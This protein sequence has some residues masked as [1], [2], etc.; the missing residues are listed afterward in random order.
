M[1][2]SNEKI[3]LLDKEKIDNF[4][5]RRAALS[6]PRI[7]T[8]FKH[9]TA[10]E[11]DIALVRKFLLTQAHV[12]DLGCGTGAIAKSIAAEC[13]YIRAVDKVSQFLDY[14][15]V[16]KNI[17]VLEADIASY[18]DEHK[19]D[20]VLIFGVMNYLTEIESKAVYRNCYDMLKPG[21]VL[22]VKHAC[23]I[24][25]D[26]FIDKFSTE[27]DDWYHAIYR[28]YKTERQLLN[29]VFTQLEMIDIYPPELNKWPNTHYYA[30]IAKK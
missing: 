30:F 27:I 16:H 28:H 17:S 11:F 25:E 21:G 20:L 13:A 18:H 9:D 15:S 2:E 6:D 8:H 26:V 10:L 24:N 5:Q 22:I 19:Y 4:W 1:I 7:A 23:G 3:D 14:C 12:L 29:Q